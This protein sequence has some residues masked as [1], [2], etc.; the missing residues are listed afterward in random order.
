MSKLAVIKT[1]GKQ[2]IVRVGDKL[3]IEKLEPSE[4]DLLF[5]TLLTTEDDG[6]AM[7]IGQPVLANA[8]GGKLVGQGRAKKVLVVH[9]KAKVRYHKKYGHRQPYSQVAIDKIG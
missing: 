3:K 7:E 8:V 6:S 2:Y 1:G 9:Y 4:G 5:T